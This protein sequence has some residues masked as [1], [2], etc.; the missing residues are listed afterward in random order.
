MHPAVSRIAGNVAKHHLLL[1]PLLFTVLGA[2]MS[3]GPLVDFSDSMLFAMAI[4]NIIGLYYFAPEVKRDLES[5]WS[6]LATGEIRK[7]KAA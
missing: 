3:L 5:Y 7:F 4:P 2:T 1:A 6:R